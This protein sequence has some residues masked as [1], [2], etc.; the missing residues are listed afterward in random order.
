[1]VGDRSV[2]LRERLLTSIVHP[3]HFGPARLG[4]LKKSSNQRPTT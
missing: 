3:P 1:M 2:L 4:Y